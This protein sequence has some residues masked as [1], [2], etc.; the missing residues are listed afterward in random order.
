M[1]NKLKIKGRLKTYLQA[2]LLLGIL[3][4]VVD[5]WIYVIDIK[6]GIVLSCFV[7]FYL[8]TVLVLMN[9]NRSILMNEL[10]SFATQYGQI[11]RQLLR[12]LELPHALLDET[13]KIIWT[14]KAFE[15]IVG[16]EK[17]YKKSVTSLFPIITKDKI[18]KNIEHTEIPFEFQGRDFVAKTHKINLKE[19]VEN[20]DI[21]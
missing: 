9:F 16:K 18:S 17:G 13:G 10:I 2:S 3:L 15:V 19:M 21:F 8:I 1:N 20:S 6:A 14:N 12:D 7:V 11:Q 5:I 4:A